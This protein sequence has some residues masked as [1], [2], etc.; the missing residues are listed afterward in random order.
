MKY[1]GHFLLW[2]II[3]LPFAKLGFPYFSM[4][5][6][7]WIITCISV[8]LILDK[9]PF[10]FYKKAL[11]I[12]TLPLLYLYP[13][14]SRCYCLIPLAIV[15]MC[16]FYKDRKEK[17]FRYLI[18]VVILANTHVIMLGMVGVV[19]LEFLFE[20]YKDSK[21]ENR[22]EIKK[23]IKSFIITVVLL[24][25]SM[26]PLLSCLTTNSEIGE[27][28][29]LAIKVFNTFIYYPLELVI[30]LFLHS[31]INI[32]I[33]AIVIVTASATLFFESK[34]NLLCYIKIFICVLW[35]CAIYSFIY[36]L[37]D[38]RAATIIFILLYYKWIYKC[39][40]TKYGKYEKRIVN[41]GWIILLVLNIFT[42]LLFVAKY[43]FNYNYSNAFELGN[44]I[45][46]NIKE[47][48]VILNGPRAEF[49]SSI[50]PYIN[51]D[52]KFYQIEGERYFS[53]TIWD[54]I[55]KLEVNFEDIK[56]LKKHFDKEDNLYYVYCYGKFSKENPDI[57]KN[58]QNMIDEC[59]Q[60][61]IFKLEYYTE[62]ISITNENYILYKIDL[63]N[64]DF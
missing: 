50:I 47:N 27:D 5:I 26:L 44:Y 12:F 30:K 51:K 36:T 56:N 63:T 52:V 6:V 11:L 53:Y 7:S 43:E 35:Q 55:N 15:L 61:G 19:L 17:P 14:V 21:N 20:L 32:I 57:N 41:I 8:W 1:E 23:R 64:F 54:E 34:N 10:K 39:N 24:I 58:E 37:S 42:G 2:Y 3:I 46:E 40:E 33:A 38:Q 60:K 48:S 45:N 62:T 31:K 59:M 9:A 22:I 13:V 28:G 4:N 18:S 29:N 25:L 16:M 49:N